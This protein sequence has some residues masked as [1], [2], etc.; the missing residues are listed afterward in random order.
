MTWSRGVAK[1]E[2]SF[3]QSLHLSSVPLRSFQAASEA[4]GT[5]FRSVSAAVTRLTFNAFNHLE[6]IEQEGWLINYP[7]P[8]QY[9]DI[10]LPRR[11][12]VSRSEDDIKLVFVGLN[13]TLDQ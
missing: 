8:R 2:V 1:K 5:N 3:Q 12:E 13:W 10:S 4:G 9:T 11:I 7:D 6:K